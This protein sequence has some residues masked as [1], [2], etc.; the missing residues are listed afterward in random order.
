MD[1]DPDMPTLIP[2][3]SMDENGYDPYLPD[4][5][6]QPSTEDTKFDP[7]RPSMTPHTGVDVNNIDNPTASD[8]KMFVVQ[9]IQELEME[10]SNNA[11]IFLDNLPAFG[12][13]VLPDMMPH[14]STMQ[15]G[16]IP[17]F[18]DVPAILVNNDN[19]ICY[20]CSMVEDQNTDNMPEL[21]EE[22]NHNKKLE[23]KTKHHLW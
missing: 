6:L 10:K 3:S 7:G 20:P 22:T 2:W 23:K 16:D 13:D 5:I 19:S 14:N 8:R 12:L 15:L 1:V 9:I 18:P 21:D 17:C 4:L 11:Q